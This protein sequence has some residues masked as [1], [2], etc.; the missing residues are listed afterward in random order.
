MKKISLLLL[1]VIGLSSCEPNVRQM[2]QQSE[3]NRKSIEGDMEL[4]M[5]KLKLEQERK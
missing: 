4:K 3:L 5:A 1:V 2:N